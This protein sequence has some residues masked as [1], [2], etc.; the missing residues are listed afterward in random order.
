MADMFEY[1]D[2]VAQASNAHSAAIEAQ[3]QESVE[4]LHDMEKM[5]PTLNN[6]DEAVEQLQ[7]FFTEAYIMVRSTPPPSFPRLYHT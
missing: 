3:L 1:L 7:P 6:M 5:R 4:A 2:S